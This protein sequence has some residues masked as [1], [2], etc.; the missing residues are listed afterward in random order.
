MKKLLL[1]LILIFPLFAFSET[2]EID[3]RKNDIYFLNGKLVT[4]EDA[5]KSSKLISKAAKKD[6]Y[7]NNE[8]AMNKE[9]NFDLLYNQTFGFYADVLEAFN[10]KKA[11]HKYFWQVLGFMFDYLG[12]VYIKPMKEITIEVVE[13]Q[14][15]PNIYI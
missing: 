9:V 11:E 8:T 10:Q 14:L 1:I 2:I 7:S 6:I 15:I 13:F 12:R 5:W 4:K 3:E